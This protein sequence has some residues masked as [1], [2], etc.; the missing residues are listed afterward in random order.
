[1]DCGDLILLDK[2]QGNYYPS[3]KHDE[4]CEYRAYIE[5][6]EEESF[7]GEL[8]KK[9]ATRDLL[10]Q[11]T[12]Q[13]LDAMPIE[14]QMEKLFELEDWYLKEFDQHGLDNIKLEI[15]RKVKTH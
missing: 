3:R 7:W 13:E 14:E 1:M 4:E 6:F 10:K 9:L 15:H 5:E 8:A 12:T 2:E 11:V